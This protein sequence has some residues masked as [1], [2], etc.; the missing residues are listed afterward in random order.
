MRPA[1]TCD[2]AGVVF[3]AVS[4]TATPF[5][6]L[7]ANTLAELGGTQFAIYYNAASRARPAI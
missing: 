2:A 1:W 3:T 5:I 7:A 4:K 6:D